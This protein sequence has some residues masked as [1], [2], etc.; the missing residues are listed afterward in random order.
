M[1]HIAVSV[2]V[3]SSGCGSPDRSRR[4]VVIAKQ[5][6]EQPVLAQRPG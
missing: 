4:P 6:A 5:R 2:Q 3:A 1:Q